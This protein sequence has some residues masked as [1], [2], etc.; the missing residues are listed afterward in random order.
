MAGFRDD[1]VN[2]LGI[3][4]PE[5]V[6]GAQIDANLFRWLNIEP[7]LGRTFLPEEGQPGKDRVILLSYALW[8][9]RF[10]GD[11]SAVGKILSIEGKDRGRAG[12]YSVVGVMKPYFQFPP[13]INRVDHMDYE[14]WIPLS[15]YG[16]NLADRENHSLQ[17]VACLKPRI[18]L[19][20]AQAEMD[21]I[22]HRIG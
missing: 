3:G 7:L 19:Q 21:E 4:E 2:I 5:L 20:R 12:S 14:A 11:P 22:T 10:G 16:A 1:D 17:V 6:S 8:Q 18:N 13:S 15:F 9:R